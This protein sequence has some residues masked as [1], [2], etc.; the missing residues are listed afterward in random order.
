M[1]SPTHPPTKQF[2]G[3]AMVEFL[4]QFFQ[5]EIEIFLTEKN[6]PSTTINEHKINSFG[7]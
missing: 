2:N 1:N 7:N 5:A 6:L 3:L 4:L